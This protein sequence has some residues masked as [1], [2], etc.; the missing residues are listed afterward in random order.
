MGLLLGVVEAKPWH[1]K[2]L[3][4]A[5]YLSCALEWGITWL[6]RDVWLVRWVLVPSTECGGHLGGMQAHHQVSGTR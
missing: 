6:A 2:R 5:L 4:S 1:V 3:P